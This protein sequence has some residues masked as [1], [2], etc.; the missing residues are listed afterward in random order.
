MRSSR[1]QRRQILIE[2]Q[3]RLPKKRPVPIYQQILYWTV[4]VATLFLVLSVV[5]SRR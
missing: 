2:L 3:R 5:F 4:I 1:E